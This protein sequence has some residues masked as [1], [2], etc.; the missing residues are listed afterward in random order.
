MKRALGI[1]PKRD[2]PR[3]AKQTFRAWFGARNGAADSR[4]E[5]VLFPDTFNNFYDPEVAIAGTH[6]LESAGFR[7]TIPQSQIC[8]GRPLYDQGMLDLAKQRLREACA[9]SVRTSSA[10]CRSWGSSRD[11]S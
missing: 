8:C 1:H 5:V 2:L 11:A 9:C 3:F 6:V 4:P 10:E 7:V